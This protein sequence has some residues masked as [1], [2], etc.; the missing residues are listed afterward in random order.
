MKCITCEIEKKNKVRTQN[1]IYRLKNSETLKKYE[2]KRYKKRK[3]YILNLN[4]KRTQNP[5]RKCKTGFV[6]RDGYKYICNPHHPNATKQGFVCERRLV[7]EAYLGRYITKNEIVHH[8]DE[9]RLNNKIAN[10]ELLKDQQ[11]H[12]LI[13]EKITQRDSKGRFLSPGVV[14]PWQSE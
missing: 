13:H 11:A 4:K 10:L 7:M 2:S 12:A 14:S 3:Q 6:I 5:F 1:I 8:K 9:N